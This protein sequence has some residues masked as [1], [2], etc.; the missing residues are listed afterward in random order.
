[1]AFTLPALPYA[2]DA[3]APP[4]PVAAAEADDEPE[5]DSAGLAVRD[6][7]AEPDADAAPV[8]L[9]DDD[10]DP[11]PDADSRGERVGTG[12]HA[13]GVAERGYQPTGGSGAGRSGPRGRLRRCSVARQ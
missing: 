10:T 1:M 11:R 13:G 4:L 6:P 9:P 3:L 5:A 2:R 12:G 7:R 8:P